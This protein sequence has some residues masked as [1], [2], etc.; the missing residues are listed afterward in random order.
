MSGLVVVRD[1]LDKGEYYFSLTQLQKTGFHPPSPPFSL[2][3]LFHCTDS[4]QTWYPRKALIKENPTTQVTRP[5]DEF[6]SR[7]S[8]ITGTAPS[9]QIQDIAAFQI[10]SPFS[11]LF[12]L[13]RPTPSLNPTTIWKV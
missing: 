10:R 5:G 11:W 4:C 2:Y 1:L 7:T 8:A 3:L 13:T 6:P 12:P 9:D